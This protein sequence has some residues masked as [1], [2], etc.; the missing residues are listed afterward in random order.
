[1]SRSERSTYRRAL[2]AALAAFF[3]I[4]LTSAFL[5]A[6]AIRAGTPVLLALVGFAFAAPAAYAQ[7]ITI[8]ASPSTYDTE[9]QLITFTYEL[10][11]PTAF[12]VT[13][14]DTI[15]P[16]NPDPPMVR[17]CPQA[18]PRFPVARSSRTRP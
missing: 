2:Y 18:A 17:E 8:S 4:I 12:T 10:S 15:T 1:M 3:Q 7:V 6:R 5:P 9:G 11:N 16:S 13:S 14:I